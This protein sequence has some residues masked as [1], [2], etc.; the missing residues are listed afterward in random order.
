MTSPAPLAIIAALMPECEALVAA[1]AAG[2]GAERV[3]LGRRDYHV[4]HLWGRP[5]VVTLARIG[6]VAAATTVTALIH[7]F[8]VERVVF[9]G[10]AGGLGD[11][12]RV[13]DVVVAD[14]L[15][16]HDLD[17]TP[18][19]PRYEVP[20]LGL[21]RFPADPALSGALADA[22]AA[23]L[24]H[25]LA[26]LPAGTRATFGLDR[27]A[28]HRGLVVSGDRFIAGAAAAA[29]LRAD[30]PEALAAE[31][32]G[33]A[34]AQ[35]CHEYGIPCGVLRIVSDSADDKAHI[36]FPAFLREVASFYTYGIV[37]RLLEAA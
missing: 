22:A 25:D 23:F 2:D 32:E 1:M 28:L 20:L 16:Q 24:T 33:A 26:E 4:G 9:T 36:D 14:H 13:G 29:A 6:K 21:A 11:G 27:P 12:V 15:V 5:C 10:V 18:L 17:A 7:R 30:L 8:G 3:H 31:M 19:F 37:R 34:V 35:V